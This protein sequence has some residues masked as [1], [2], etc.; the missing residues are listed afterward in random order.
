MKPVVTDL[1]MVVQS[2]GNLFTAVGYYLLE[3]RM[4]RGENHLYWFSTSS[5]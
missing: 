3:R 5:W 1:I 4:E 2:F